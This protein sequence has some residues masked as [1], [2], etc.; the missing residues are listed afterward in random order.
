MFELGGRI[1]PL[2]TQQ[3]CFVRSSLVDPNDFNNSNCR[4]SW[5]AQFGI[6]IFKPS[7]K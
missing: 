7:L 1:G 3:T 5:F 4:L 2:R 6:Q